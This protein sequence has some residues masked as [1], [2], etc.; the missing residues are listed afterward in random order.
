VC[1]YVPC[2][3]ASNT[4]KEDTKIY[5]EYVSWKL[6]EI[7]NALFPVVFRSLLLRKTMSDALVLET[8]S[9][10]PNR[11]SSSGD[12]FF[13]GR[14][15]CTDEMNYKGYLEF[16]GEFFPLFTLQS[17]KSDISVERAFLYR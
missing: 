6:T 15:R 7:Y 11:M 8:G 2:N 14:P 16:M 17:Q 5:L 12:A 4:V 3:T 10:V 9:S 1:N 13:R